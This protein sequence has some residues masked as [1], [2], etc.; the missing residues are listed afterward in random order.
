MHVAWA[1]SH[2]LVQYR[3]VFDNHMPLFHLMWA[4]L[5][6]FAGDDVNVL[7]LAR[8]SVLPFF[9]ASLYLV[10]RIAERLFDRRIAFWAT[11]F[12][13][14]LPPFFLGMLEYRT[15]DV[16]VVFWLACIYVLI[17]ATEPLQRSVAAG[18]LLGLAFGISMKSVL[19]AIAIV[20]AGI[21]TVKLMRHRPDPSSDD[22]VAG[23]L[24]TLLATALVI[25]TAI[26]CLFA[27]AGVWR[28]FA[29]CVLWHNTSAPIDHTWW[30]VF[31]IVP[32]APLTV[33]V[34]R[35]Y[36]AADGDDGVVRRRLFVFLVCASYFIVLSALWPI[37][38]LES[39]L[40]FYPLAAILLTPVLLSWRPPR[41]AMTLAV[42][43]IVTTAAMG[44]IWRD[45][46]HQE[47]SL[48]RQVLQITRPDDTVMDLKGE[49][50]FRK[51]PYWFVLESITHRKF[52]NHVLR[53]DIAA[54]LVRSGT[55]VL[56][57][58][59][60]PADTRRFVH[61]NYVPWGR[62]WVVGHQILPAPPGGAAV[63]FRVAV[64]S[65]Y[66][67]VDARGRV[68]ASI[69]GAPVGDGVE[70]SRGWHRVAMAR[71]V[72]RPL[73]IWSSVTRSPAF[74]SRLRE[75]EDRIKRTGRVSRMAGGMTAPENEQ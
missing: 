1:W 24:V 64:P 6:R 49:S 36:A 45:D 63:P 19:F 9:C 5:F 22:R 38:A 39:Y 75:T 68:D 11:A 28:E 58:T 72:S 21:G 29:Y 17:S 60:F 15:D 59:D 14:L 61:H 23:R 37:L 54:A 2:G 4:P 26:A 35:G 10:F 51:R 30:R 41:F 47:V 56:A 69:D 52:R 43:L 73:V 27:I 18:A 53:D 25:P 57:S 48:I 20:L 44:K 67:I 42:L 8:L 32:L 31:W 50:L 34:A 40:P 33:R 13:A 62:L 74:L 71:N 7:Y 12:T 55:A 46:A 16:W 65:R 70:L 3:D 66:I